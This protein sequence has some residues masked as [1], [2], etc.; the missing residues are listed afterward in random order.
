M[1][2]ETGLLLKTAL[3]FIAYLWPPF[4]LPM[5]CTASSSS[6]APFTWITKIPQVTIRTAP[7]ED[8]N[9]FCTIPLTSVYHC[10][11]FYFSI[12]P[13]LKLF[14][15]FY[16]SKGSTPPDSSVSAPAFA[17][18]M[19]AT[20][21]HEHNPISKS[22]IRL[23]LWT[24][25]RIYLFAKYYFQCVCMPAYLFVCLSVRQLAYLNKPSLPTTDPCDAVP[26]ADR[27]VHRCRLS[28]RWTV[29]ETDT[30]LPHWPKLTAPETI[31]RS[32]DM[33]KFKCLT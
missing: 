2:A 3:L 12:L 33:S 7:A 14:F 13:H 5:S 20:W 1:Q 32:R 27:V 23:P 29:T 10:N 21:T 18:F 22:W 11:V 6:D 17:G 26:Q 9:I 8:G 4:V 19:T 31:S 15:K 24:Y 30:S 28:M 25:L 16:N